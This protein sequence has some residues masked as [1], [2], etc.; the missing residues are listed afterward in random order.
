MF[1][2]FF[3]FAAKRFQLTFQLARL[4]ILWYTKLLTLASG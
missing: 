2:S 3:H 1:S 4:H